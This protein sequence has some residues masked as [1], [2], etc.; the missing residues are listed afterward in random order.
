MLVPV[1]V[2]FI[3][4][5]GGKQHMQREYNINDV[6]DEARVGTVFASERY[7]GFG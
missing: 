2:Y 7:L 5:Q 6:R 4:R 1:Y 3:V